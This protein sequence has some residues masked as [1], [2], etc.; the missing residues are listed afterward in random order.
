LGYYDH[1]P[2]IGWLF[3][4]LLKVSNA[5]WWL[6][7]PVTLLPFAL[8]AGVYCVLRR[9]DEGKAALAAL[10][11]LL[12]P[13]NVWAV[14]ITTDTPLILFS[15]ASVFAFWLGLEKKSVLWQA[16]AGAFLGLA[17]LSKY[18]AVLLGVAYV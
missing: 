2:M 13:A 5:V 12:L 8:A 6:R 15:S 11:F 4:L 7:L 1:P 9:I 3:I 16:L 10:A 14:L 18:F 17:F